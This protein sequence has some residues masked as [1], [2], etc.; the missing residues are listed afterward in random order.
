MGI[1]IFIPPLRKMTGGLYVLATIADALREQGLPVTFV[2]R[3]ARTMPSLGEDF[4][5]IPLLP[6]DQLRLTADDVWLVPEGWPNALAPGLT[7][8]ARCIVYCQNWAYLFSGLP[9]KVDLRSLAVSFIAVSAPVA[10]YIQQT[11]GYESPILRP[12]IDLSLFFALNEKPRGRLRIAY[13]PRKNK[14]QVEQIRAAF[15]ALQVGRGLKFSDADFIPIENMDRAGVAHTLQTSHI[16]LATGFPE[17]CPLPPLEAMACGCIP[18]GFAGFG[19]FDYMRQVLPD[20]P[21]AFR[22]W[23]PLPERE[24]GGNSLVAAD[25]DVLGAARLL[26]YAVELMNT[27]HV[28]WAQCVENAQLTARAYD[29]THHRQQAVALFRN[30]IHA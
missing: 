22:P 19:G 26:D 9:D 8:K 25:N 23:W 20:A 29:I 10:L 16:F 7:A 5:T 21:G 12:G 6:L 28:L 1:F 15:C 17:G 13:M 18:V 4:H 24:W 27:N 11:L 30:L 14:A 2:P 3:D